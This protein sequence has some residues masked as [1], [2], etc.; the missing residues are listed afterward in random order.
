MLSYKASGIKKRKVRFKVLKKSAHNIQNVVVSLLRFV[1]T[2]VLEI[3][4]K[5][6]TRFDNRLLYERGA[7]THVSNSN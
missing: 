4:I 2:F 1:F 7:D 5:F 6:N 3:Q